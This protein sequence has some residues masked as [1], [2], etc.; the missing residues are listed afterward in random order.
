MA[1]H[2]FQTYLLLLLAILSGWPQAADAAQVTAAAK[3]AVPSK[4]SLYH[5]V[6]RPVL[7][8]SAQRYYEA[9]WGVDIVG[10]KAV[11]SGTM[12]R[13]SYRVTD[14]SKAQPLND[15]KSMPYLYDYNSRARLEVP[16]MEKV[17]QLRQSAPVQEGQTYWMVFANQQRLV[18]PGSRVDIVIGS[19]HARGILV[20]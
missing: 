1:K 3:T 14:A 9:T 19:F 16:S 20:E 4:A 13:F 15:K 11:E 17:G 6:A 7:P 8:V 10:V 12:L 2:F 18:K 5:R